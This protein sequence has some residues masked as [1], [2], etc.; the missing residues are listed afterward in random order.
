MESE[1]IIHN[2]HYYTDKKRQNATFFPGAVLGGYIF[3]IAGVADV[4]V[5]DARCLV[6]NADRSP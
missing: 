3:S 5:G 4:A 2:T 6:Y 1:Y